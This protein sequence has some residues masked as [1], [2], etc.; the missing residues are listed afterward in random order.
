LLDYITW[1]F[2]SAHQQNQI[3]QEKTARKALLSKLT[4]LEHQVFLHFMHGLSNKRIAEILNL[5]ADTIKKRRAQI[6]EKLQVSNL[7]ELLERYIKDVNLS[8]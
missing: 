1:A 5:K 4:P 7:A 3:N 6:Y 8:N 2:A